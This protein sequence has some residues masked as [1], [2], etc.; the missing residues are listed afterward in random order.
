MLNIYWMNEINLPVVVR[1]SI[2]FV[3]FDLSFCE[4]EYLSMDACDVS[5]EATLSALQ[6]K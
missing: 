6:I 5:L 2:H 4:P 3:A 1:P